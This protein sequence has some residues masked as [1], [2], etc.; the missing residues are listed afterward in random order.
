ML[1]PPVPLD[2]LFRD[3][4]QIDRIVVAFL[5]L[6]R[7]CCGKPGRAAMPLISDR[8]GQSSRGSNGGLDQGKD[9]RLRSPQHPA[10]ARG[11]CY[12]SP[13]FVAGAQSKGARGQ[14]KSLYTCWVP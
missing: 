10:V 3:L 1:A 2:P 14:V 8:H 6:D 13:W 7:F 11:R 9:G 4:T 5:L 12:S